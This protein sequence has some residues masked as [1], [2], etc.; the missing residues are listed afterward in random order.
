MTEN[1][2]EGTATTEGSASEAETT[3]ASESQPTQQ[4][5]DRLNAALAKERDLRRNLEK[6]QRASMT[7]AERALAEA[8]TRGRTAAIT[9][10]GKRI[11]RTEFDAIAARRNPDFDT[12]SALEFVDLGK[13]VGEDGEP[14]TKAIKAA[15]E[16]LVPERTQAATFDGGARSTATSTDMNTLIRRAAGHG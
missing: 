4:D 2:T 16:R 12:A 11:A 7:E 1:S 8:E 14:D 6:Q 13:F 5:I 9:D 10:F 15:V 3:T